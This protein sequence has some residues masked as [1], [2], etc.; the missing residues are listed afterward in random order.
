MKITLDVPDGENCNMCEYLR[1][2]GPR[3]KIFKS[4]LWNQDKPSSIL[5]YTLTKERV[6]F[7]KHPDC[8][9]AGEI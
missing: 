2:S 8:I 4:P 3:C 5:G 9:K 6:I 7:H 1:E